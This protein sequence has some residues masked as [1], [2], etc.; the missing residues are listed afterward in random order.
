MRPS[1]NK[2]LAVFAGFF[3]AS[4]II[5]LGPG[6]YLLSFAYNFGDQSYILLVPVLSALLVHR[7]QDAVFSSIHPGMSPPALIGLVA[8]I[9]FIL[10][11]Y[12]LQSGTEF[13]MIVTAVGLIAFWVG[14]FT[15]CFGTKSARAA[16]FPL[17]MLLWLIPI[18]F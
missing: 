18:P 14:A 11:G 4:I 12:F 8:G 6:R 7:E 13:Q 5:A 3:I 17:A 15:F 9:G 16:A 2:Q 1:R 10:A